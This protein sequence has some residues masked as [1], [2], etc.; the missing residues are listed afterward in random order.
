MLERPAYLPVHVWEFYQELIQP[1]ESGRPSPVA[2]P[3]YHT[4]LLRLF[5]LHP[6]IP[7]DRRGVPEIAKTWRAL[8]RA[9]D[10]PANPWRREDWRHLLDLFWT[11]P[12]KAGLV[13]YANL[14][15]ARALAPEISDLA[16]RLAGALAECKDL[17]MQH[18]ISIP[19]E[20]LSTA[21]WIDEASYL[22]TND[23]QNLFNQCCRP[24]FSPFNESNKVNNCYLP[25]PWLML[26]QLANAFDNYESSVR[27]RRDAINNATEEPGISGIVRSFERHWSYYQ[28][29][30]RPHLKPPQFM[31]AKFRIG[32]TDLARILAAL[33]GF[34]FSRELVKAARK[35]TKG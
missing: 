14:R 3:K 6:D 18:H 22:D 11:L 27:D 1:D 33:F 25:R 30:G 20:V 32:D 7:R 35:A 28:G 17:I 15:R 29:K 26:V 4:P 34:E 2:L 13:D 10:A 9:I 19:M 8:E 5:G 24:Y 21:Y 16:R 31:W 23:N 12:G